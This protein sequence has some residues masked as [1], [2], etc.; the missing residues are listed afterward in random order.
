MRARLGRVVL[1]FALLLAQQS[2]LAHQIWHASLVSA[3]AFAGAV[4]GSEGSDD[5]TP[6]QKQLCELHAALGAVLGVLQGA[7]G[8]A[9][10]AEAP[11]SEFVTADPPAVSL[12]ALPPA[13]RGPPQRL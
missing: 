2:A 9:Q 11:R 6:P 10:L 4:A 3:H 5:S 7:A 13:S 8:L 1:V 12:P